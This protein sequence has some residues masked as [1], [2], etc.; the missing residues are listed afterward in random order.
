[1]QDQERNARDL[2]R[3]SR[4]VPLVF[5][6]RLAIS[7][8]PVNEP[9]ISGTVAG[10]DFKSIRPMV[11]GPVTEFGL[12]AQIGIYY[13]VSPMISAGASFTTPQNFDFYEWN[14]VHGNPDLEN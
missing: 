1:M 3:A 5:H 6:G 8:N 14:S 11:G 9:D 12:G 4:R 10:G 7:P 13:E 2:N